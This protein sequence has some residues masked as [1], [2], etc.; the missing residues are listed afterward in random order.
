MC[1]AVQREDIDLA[2]FEVEYRKLVEE[3]RVAK[4]VFLIHVVLAV[5][6]SYTVT[7]LPTAQIKEI[8]SLLTK[9]KELIQEVDNLGQVQIRLFLNTLIFTIV[10]YSPGMQGL[11]VL[12]ALSCKSGAWT[13]SFPT[14]I[15]E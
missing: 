9:S 4:W 2:A 5:V 15:V 11:R 3:T 10:L 6:L 1:Q 13:D 12:I 8:V 14:H 7:V